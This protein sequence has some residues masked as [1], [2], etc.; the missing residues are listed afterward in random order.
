MPRNVDHDERRRDI[1]RAAIR[2]LAK[3]G[4]RGLTLRALADELGGSITLV[5]HFFPNRRALLDAVTSQAIE[6]IPTDLASAEDTQLAPAERLRAFLVWLLPTTAEA[7]QL[8]RSRV[9]LSAESDAHFNVQDFFD[10][11]ERTTRDLIERYVTPLVP[12]G[13]RQFYIDLLRVVQNGVV[14]SSVEHPK[15]WTP[16]RQIEFID[17]LVPVIEQLSG[18]PG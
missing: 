5:T 10:T 1:A 2:L 11:W 3:S 12:E 7:L 18:Q 16:E 4:P 15:Y 13:E 14:L 8:E 6:D 17:A 9:L